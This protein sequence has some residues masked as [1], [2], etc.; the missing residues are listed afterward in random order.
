MRAGFQSEVPPEESKRPAGRASF[1]F[2]VGI[3]FG[4]MYLA[5]FVVQF[6][7]SQLRAQKEGM[8]V[9]LRPMML[10]LLVQSERPGSQNV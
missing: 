6:L 2:A 7:G 10:G 1:V 8:R 9:G 4:V 5:V 3:G